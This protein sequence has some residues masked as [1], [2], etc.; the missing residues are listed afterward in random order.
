M[1]DVGVPS[2]PE[3]FEPT[4]QQPL[5]RKVR[6]GGKVFGFAPDADD[7]SIKTFFEGFKK[8]DEFKALI[9]RE[10]G[11]PVGIRNIVGRHEDAATQLKQLQRYYPDA[12][13]Y[14]EDN[15]LFTDGATGKI[16][17]YNPKGMDFGDVAEYGREI[18]EGVFSAGGAA[19]GFLGG[20]AV[21]LPTGPGAIATS[22][23]GGVLGA[24][25]GAEAGARLYDLSMDFFGGVPRE[26]GGIT[27]VFLE[28]AVRTGTAAVGEAAGPV[29]A[30]GAKKLLGGGTA[31]AKELAD[32]FMRLKID[33]VASTITEGTGVGRLQAALEQA[34]SSANDIYKQ[35][36]TVM[37]QVGE[38]ANKIASKFG[39]AREKTAAGAMVK[40][41]VEA[42]RSRASTEFSRRY[43]AAFDAIDE[44]SPVGALDEVND[45]LD[46]HL[47][48]LKNLPK[49]AAPK[50]QMKELI[51]KYEAISK[52]AD[53]GEL[54]FGQLRRFRT[55]LLEVQRKTSM[56]TAGDLDSLIDDLA[57]AMT[58]DMS[59]AASSLNPD[60]AADLALLDKDYAKYA[61]GAKKTFQKI[62]DMDADTA[63]FEYILTSARSKGKEGVNAL[64]R[65]KEHFTA[66]E[67]GDVSASV[68][69]DLGRQTPGAQTG[70]VAEFSANTFMT[71]IA[72]I[73]EAGPEAWN[74]LFT[75]RHTDLG[76][77]LS[78]LIDVAGRLKDVEQVRNRSQ[79]AGALFNL[80]TFQALGVGMTGMATSGEATGLAGAVGAVVAPKMAAKLL[81]SPGFVNWLAEPVTTSRISSHIG[82]LLAIGAA[83]PH[84]QEELQQFAS[85]LRPVVGYDAGTQEDSP[86]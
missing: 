15:Y 75:G 78:D 77:E 6:F 14:D 51:E 1:T 5:R 50:G 24:G 81:T 76:R 8:T 49:E 32:K 46:R 17:L 9:D 79:T 84:I 52:M 10:S 29:I 30:G 72:K 56:N 82:R 71:R 42:A 64:L 23:A 59:K 33:P 25:V 85:A 41:T 21:G 31:R 2:S 47:W 45:V 20:G 4:L 27:D 57:G 63:A 37:T 22:V 35:A 11:A 38:A 60:A 67:W 36:D 16:T 48:D 53:N 12:Q 74:T 54:D 43:D 34:A 19:A 58:D 66:D 39:V 73:K 55:Q 80:M 44:L 40:E 7:N 13:P 83:E 18:T 70:E 68:L 28:S 26:Q 86:E 69:A 62:R 61:S 65:L 3:V